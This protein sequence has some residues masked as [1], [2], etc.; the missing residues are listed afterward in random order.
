MASFNKFN[1][2]VEDIAHGVHNLSSGVITLAFTVAASAPV[3]T[4]EVL[5]DLTDIDPA[6][7]DDITPTKA[8]SS[9][10]SGTYT[11][12]M[13]DHTIT[14][15]GTVPTFRYVVHYNDTP[16]SPA[17]PLICWHDHGSDVDLATSETYD[18]DYGTELF[19][20]A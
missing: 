6:N 1:Q 4:N 19:S 7:M 16:T 14:A 12:V 13:T 18:L 2:F 20:L 15:T 9:Q 3:A 10:T 8:S 11:L 5:A 17:D